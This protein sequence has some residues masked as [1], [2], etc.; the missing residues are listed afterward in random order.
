[1]NPT[2]D[3]LLFD[4]VC[5]LLKVSPR[6]LY[7]LIDRGVLAFAEMERFDRHRR[8]SKRRLQTWI[9]TKLRARL[10]SDVRRAS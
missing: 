10:T 8:W 4:D 1:M 5:A 3:V 2:D 7:R 6:Q 9:D